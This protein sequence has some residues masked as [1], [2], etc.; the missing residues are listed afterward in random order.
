MPTIIIIACYFIGSIIYAFCVARY[1][2]QYSH[3]MVS[4]TLLWP[5][6]LIGWAVS[7]IEEWFEEKVRWWIKLCRN[8]RSD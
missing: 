5:L 7:L 3:K 1:S 4:L 6:V 2:G 8:G